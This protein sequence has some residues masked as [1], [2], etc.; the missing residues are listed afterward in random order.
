MKKYFESQ[1]AKMILI[2]TYLLLVAFVLIPAGAIVAIQIL[3]LGNIPYHLTGV[4]IAIGL[5]DAIWFLTV[6][7]ALLTYKKLQQGSV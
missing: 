4:Y 1:Q 5:V 6:F 2:S 7:E 3:D